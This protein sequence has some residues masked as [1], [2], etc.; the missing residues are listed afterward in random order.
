MRK[1]KFCREAFA[2]KLQNLLAQFPMID[3]IHPFYADLLNIFYDR[4]HY[5]AALGQVRGVANFLDAVCSDYVRLLKYADGPYKCKMLKKAALGR[6][7]SAVRRLKQTLAYLAQVRTHLARLPSVNVYAKTILLAGHPNVGKST[8][9]NA[10]SNANVETAEWAFTTKNIFVGHFYF[11]NEP[12]QVLD[13]PGVLDRPLSARNTIEMS[14]IVAMAHLQAAVLYLLDVSTQCGYSIAEQVSLFKTLAPLLKTKPV[15]VVLNKTDLVSLEDLSAEERASLDSMKELR[16]Q[17]IVSQE[18]WRYDIVP[19]IFDG[20][21]VA[22]F[23]DSD[24]LQKLEQLEAEETHEA[25]RFI[26]ERRPKHLYS[27]KRSIGK[28]DRR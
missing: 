2:E 13:T 10:L 26:G 15:L 18:E 25:D 21:N 12:W 22:D 20:K 9:M 11:D 28:T 16:K 17:W 5:K 14:A 23:V 19:E 6:M 4:D 1:I 27:G 8:F 7:C 3:T 24:I